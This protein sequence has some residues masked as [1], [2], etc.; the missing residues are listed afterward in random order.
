MG[1]GLE[2]GAQTVIVDHD[3]ID[4][5]DGGGASDLSCELGLQFTCLGVGY[6]ASWDRN[7]NGGVHCCS[8]GGGTGLELEF[9][10]LVHDTS[11]SMR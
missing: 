11:E 8:C 2:R 4:S 10:G 5:V 7:G 9:G 6:Y 3:F 1:H